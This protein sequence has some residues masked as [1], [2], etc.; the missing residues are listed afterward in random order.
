MDVIGPMVA[1]VAMLLA[2]TVI[3]RSQLQS[4]L[5]R[6][7]ARQQAET[8]RQLLERFESPQALAD[9]LGS[10]AGKKLMEVPSLE[11]ATVVE[12]VLSSVRAGI[13]L[14]A[15]GAAFY[16]VRGYVVGDSYNV[17]SVLGGLALALGGGSIVS[18]VVTFVLSK[19]WGL[20]N[21]ASAA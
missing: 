4:R 18:A 2:A 11:K 1:V 14:I 12:R 17:F 20:L 21:G 16:M 5:Q 3:W 8:Q 13:L 15:I 19:K 7:L 10:E 6:D 9:Y